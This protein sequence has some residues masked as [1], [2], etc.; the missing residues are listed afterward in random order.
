MQAF[1]SAQAGL[2]DVIQRLKTNVIVDGNTN[3]TSWSTTASSS[4]PIGGTSSVTITHVRDGFGNAVLFDSAQK[5]MYRFTS[6]G[7]FNGNTRVLEQVVTF[8]PV[9]NNPVPRWGN[10]VTG[11][12][13]VIV[14]NNAA[15]DSYNSGLGSYGG[16]NLGDGGDIWASGNVTINNNGGIKGNIITPGTLTLNNNAFVIGNATSGGTMTLNNGAQIEKNNG[17][18]GNASAGQSG[19]P[20]ANIVSSG[21]I[22]GTATASGTIGGTVNGTKTP[23]N[24]NIPVVPIP[25]ECQ[26]QNLLQSPFVGGQGLANASNASIVNCVSCSAGCVTASGGKYNCSVS[27]NGQMTLPGSSDPNHPKN[28]YFDSL[29]LS[30]NALLNT[31]GYANIYVNGNFSASN[32]NVI[33][34]MDK[35]P[36]ELMIY[37][38]NMGSA[39]TVSVSNNCQIY[40]KLYA[41][42]VALNMSNNVQVYGAVIA[43]S[44]VN[45]VTMANNENVHYDVQISMPAFMTPD[46]PQGYAL[47]HLKECFKGILTT[48][49]G[50]YAAGACVP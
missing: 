31:T 21:T 29:T 7:T 40:G 43:G 11:C 39:A 46:I 23:N 15:T 37:V 26:A 47:Y 12:G 16:A 1:Y 14:S 27:N 4:L 3:S 48:A 44:N 30:N 42:N 45:Q 8:D 10:A 33:E 24:A 28:Y 18:G 49:Q 32:N 19:S 35:K 13:S 38:G 9:V 22:Q 25:P 34:P 41:P 2:T 5:N 50:E 20:T 17:L 36:P 6:T